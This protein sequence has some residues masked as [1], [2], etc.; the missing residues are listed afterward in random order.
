[1]WLTPMI[2]RTAQEVKIEAALG[3]TCGNITYVR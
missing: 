2:C 3:L 1:M